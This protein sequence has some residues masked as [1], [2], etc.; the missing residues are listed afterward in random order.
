MRQHIRTHHVVALSLLALLWGGIAACGDDPADDC[1]VG[2]PNEGPTC[3]C[4]GAECICPSSGDCAIFCTAECGL[5]CAGSGSCDFDCGPDCDIACTGSGNCTLTVGHGSTVDCT[6]S[7]DCDVVCKGDC[8]VR[9]PGSGDC[10]VHCEPGAV[11]T[12]DGV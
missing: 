10:V 3:E 7:G 12:T 9:C 1:T 8:D 5:Q 6:G 2:D 4:N 11:C